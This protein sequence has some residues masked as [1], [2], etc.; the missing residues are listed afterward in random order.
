M[1]VEFEC[2]HCAGHVC[3]VWCPRGSSSGIRL[4][5]LHWLLNPG[6]ALIELLF[7]QRVPE[8][9][10]VCKSCPLPLPLRS[11]EYCPHCYTFLRSSLW[12]GDHALGHWL[13]FFCPTCGGSIPCMWNAASR[14]V[15]ALTS[16]LWW[17]PVL[18]LKKSW[19]RSE[20]HRARIAATAGSQ[21]QAL[22]YNAVGT[23]F[24]IMA[25]FVCSVYLVSPL[26]YIFDFWVVCYLVVWTM[27]LGLLA[28]LPTGW[29]FAVAMRNLLEKPGDPALYLSVRD[30]SGSDAMP[31]MGLGYAPDPVAELC[32]GD[33]NI[34][35]RSSC[36]A[37]VNDCER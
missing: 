4:I 25:N 31:G 3:E 21:Y 14:V 36:A 6:V 28:W 33:R 8:R 13:G 9:T 15:L 34:S 30:V 1:L 16:P 10:Y 24:G 18:L 37:V 35:I 32:D 11:Y 29:L 26:T 23:W 17:L 5:Y 20:Q 27:T 2:P 12:S 7:G 22:D 19:I